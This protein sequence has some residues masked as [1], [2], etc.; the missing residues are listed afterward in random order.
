MLSS[1]LHYIGKLPAA[2]EKRKQSR[3]ISINCQI[4]WKEVGGCKVV[5]VVVINQDLERE[6]PVH[7]G[8]WDHNGY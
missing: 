4:M 6:I 1:P 2:D 3:R 7:V 8:C 5:V